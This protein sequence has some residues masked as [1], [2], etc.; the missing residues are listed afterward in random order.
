VEASR[1][2]L[3]MII[4]NRSRI[5]AVHA[6]SAFKGAIREVLEAP[7]VMSQIKDTKVGRLGRGL[8]FVP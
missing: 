3:R 7:E 5:I 6:S 4:E 2:D 1:R 8:Y